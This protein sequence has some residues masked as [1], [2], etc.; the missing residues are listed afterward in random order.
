VLKQVEF[1][2]TSHKCCPFFIQLLVIIKSH[3]IKCAF[4][5]SSPA[6]RGIIGLI[7]NPFS[8]EI[9]VCCSNIQRASL[10]L[11]QSVRLS[12]KRRLVLQM[13]REFLC[14]NLCIVSSALRGRGSTSPH[15]FFFF[16]LAQ[17]WLKPALGI[18]V[19][20]ITPLWLPE[21]FVR[22]VMKISPAGAQ[23]FQKSRR[24]KGE[25]KQLRYR[26][27]TDIRCALQNLVSATTLRPKFVHP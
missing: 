9:P 24:R 22:N 5:P 25:M 16:A 15:S 14:V 23:I 7:C 11:S 17:K 4:H 2:C 8:L 13:C 19:R 26:G 18:L 3:L 10:G 20:R 27:S 12:H 6:F 21:L 1:G